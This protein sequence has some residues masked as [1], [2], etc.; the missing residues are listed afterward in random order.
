MQTRL[1]TPLCRL[2]SAVLASL[3]CASALQAQVYAPTIHTVSIDDGEN[4]RPGSTLVIRFMAS[5]G[6]LPLESLTFAFVNSTGNQRSLTTRAPRDGVLSVPVTEDWLN[7]IHRLQSVTAVNGLMNTFYSESSF[8]SNTAQYAV[9]PGPS[10]TLFLTRFVVSEARAYA[11]PTLTAA[12]RVGAPDVAA[13][14]AVTLNAA[15]TA[16][17]A[18]VQRI[19]L[20]YDDP[21][22]ARITVSSAE[23]S[24]QAILPTGTQWTNGP[25]ALQSIGIS[26]AA[27]QSTTYFRNGRIDSQNGAVAHAIDLAACDFTVTGGF[28]GTFVFPEIGTFTLRST[29][30]RVG[31][32]IAIDYA[33]IIPGARPLKSVMFTLNGPVTIARVT[34]NAAGASGT[35]T[36]TV[37]AAMVSGRYTLNRIDLI[38]V[39]DSRL[40]TRAAAPRAT[41]PFA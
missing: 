33:L 16:G 10:D 22:G 21:N 13:G 18:A 8:V 25:Y 9:P 19:F 28:G 15:I 30:A 29:E 36:F 14:A 40:S 31:D 37:P 27:G 20:S 23:N 5:A 12:S 3:C 17:S 2:L 38:D 32:T 6:S 35:A 1:F 41:L 7:G 39:G 34:A 24:L 4:L 26:D 11:K